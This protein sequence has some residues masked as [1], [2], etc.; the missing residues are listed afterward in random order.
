MLLKTK[1]K[2]LDL[3]FWA[4]TTIMVLAMIG[5]AVTKQTEWAFVFTVPGILL[6][7]YWI[8]YIIVSIYYEK[9]N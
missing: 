1:A 8:L 4:M 3:M 5:Y 2:M 6:A 7:F 9:H